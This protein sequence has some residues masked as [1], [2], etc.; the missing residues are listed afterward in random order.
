MTINKDFERKINNYKKSTVLIIIS[1]FIGLFW[2]LA[3]IFGWSEYSLEGALISCSVEWN[4]KTTS[5]MSYN[6]SILLFVFFIPI[7]IL[8]YT[9]FMIIRIVKSS[10]L[11]FSYAHSNIQTKK[12]V[13]AERVLTIR[14]V[15]LLCNCL[16]VFQNLFKMIKVHYFRFFRFFMDS[17]CNRM[18]L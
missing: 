14:F 11:Q 17:V 18:Y 4:K 6:M 15:F 9:N 12:R 1:I 8:I 2:A 10:R 7:S 3:P 5:V 16:N 13:K